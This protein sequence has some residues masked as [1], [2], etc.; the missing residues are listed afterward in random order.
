MN[1]VAALAAGKVILS[2]FEQATAIFKWPY[3]VERCGLNQYIVFHTLDDDDDDDDI[4]QEKREMEQLGRWI[5][6]V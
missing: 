2:S 1:A 4:R 5:R 6:P 3:K